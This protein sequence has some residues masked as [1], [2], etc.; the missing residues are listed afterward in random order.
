MRIAI[1]TESFLPQIN[2]VTNTV[3]HVVD[4]LRETGHETLVIA[5]GPGP[6]SYGPTPVVRVRS[7]PVPMYAS[8]PMGVPDR[9]LGRA[10]DDFQPDLLHVASPAFLGAWALMSARRRCIPSVAIFQTDLAGFVRQ[11]PLVRSVPG[12]DQPIWMGMRWLHGMADR[13]LAP[14][15]ETLSQLRHARVP[16]VHRWGR[17]V[18]LSLFDPEMRDDALRSELAPHGELL[19]GYV[20]RLAAEKRVRRLADLAD[21][22]GVRLV[23][24]GDGPE[25]PALRRL[26][27]D[28]PD[29]RRAMRAAVTQIVAD[30]AL[31][32]RVAQ[33]GAKAVAGRT[34]AA[35]VDRLVS[36]HYSAVV[37]PS[38]SR[39]A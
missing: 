21:L 10:L 13:T 9:A 17:G 38:L 18:D 31:R 37:A 39:V 15:M 8:F 30:P 11:Y 3:C 33:G 32:Q 6:G 19:V 16:R 23:I 35:V 36:E 24:V 28:D 12:L 1:V 34:W 25:A 29:D 2:G 14:S 22:P 5:P 20:G 4:R 26:I 7:V 27:P